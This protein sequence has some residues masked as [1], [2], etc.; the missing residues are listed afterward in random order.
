[1][2]VEGTLTRPASRSKRIDPP[3]RIFSLHNIHGHFH[4]FIF[5][6]LEARILQWPKLIRATGLTASRFV[7]SFLRLCGCIFFWFC[8]CHR[9]SIDAHRPIESIS[10]LKEYERRGPEVARPLETIFRARLVVDDEDAGQ[11]I[12]LIIFLS[13]LF[14]FFLL[15]SGVSPPIASFAF[16][17][18][19]P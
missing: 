12:F 6:A 19:S 14:F 11:G 1:M 8:A 5:V 4:Y 18:A 13:F 10:P 7:S 16:T 3:K 2:K 9:L 15:L 17:P